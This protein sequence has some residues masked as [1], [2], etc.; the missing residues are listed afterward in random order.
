M[1]P[2][3]VPP[4]GDVDLGD[5]SQAAM[6]NHLAPGNGDDGGDDA[7]GA[8]GDEAGDDNENGPG[9][10]TAVASRSRGRSGRVYDPDSPAERLKGGC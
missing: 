5:G 7:G 10:A 8:S 3:V 1:P 2:F 9:E 6:A 4:T